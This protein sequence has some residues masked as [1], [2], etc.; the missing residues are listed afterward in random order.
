MSFDIHIERSKRK[1]R[2]ISIISMID[3]ILF[4][5]MYFV[6]VGRI[7]NVNVL[8]IDIPLSEQIS[9][10]ALGEA[11]ITLGKR[12]EILAG[13]DVMFNMDEL[14]DWIEKRMARNPASRFTIKADADME[15]VKLIELMQ[16]MEQS[17]AHD[18]VLAAQKP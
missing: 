13:D 5:I 12:Q 10:V 2:Q 9:E 16:A 15:A 18:V 7:D 8:P 14:K 3:I 6:V 4:M 1:Q 17:G 11:I